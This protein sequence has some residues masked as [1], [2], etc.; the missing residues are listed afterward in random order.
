MTPESLA[1]IVLESQEPEELESQEPEEV[2]KPKSEDLVT[3]ESPAL[4]VLESQEPEEVV[5]PKSEDSL[6][7]GAF[8]CARCHAVHEDREAWNQV[9]SRFR[10]C[11]RCNLVHE[12]Y[13]VAAM[14]H[15]LDNFDCF[16][17]IPDLDE[18]KMD[19]KTIILPLR[20]LKMLA[21]GNVALTQDS[22]R[23]Q[24]KEHR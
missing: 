18:L 2:V 7:P 16:V 13:R 21:T 4:V 9:H 8:V 22:H 23:E 1:L 14:L 11:S 20:V 6:P 17:F 15:G 19:G 3:P 24:K 5:K 10:P 12:D